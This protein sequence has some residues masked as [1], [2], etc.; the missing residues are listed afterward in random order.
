MPWAR[1]RM[2]PR[3]VFD[4]VEGDQ[5]QWNR[6]CELVAWSVWQIVMSIPSLS[7]SSHKDEWRR[8]SRF[9]ELQAPPGYRPAPKV[10]EKRRR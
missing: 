6:M 10:K 1:D 3:D 9:L 7:R 8:F 2:Q 5:Q 4:L